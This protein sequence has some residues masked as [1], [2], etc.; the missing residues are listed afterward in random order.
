MTVS[1]LEAECRALVRYLSGRDPP[2]YVVACY[3]RSAGPGEPGL[4]P[5]DRGLMRA[6][7][8]ARWLARPAD[9]YARAARPAGLLRRRLTLA[10]AIL[11][12]A[13]ESHRELNDARVGAPF[14]IWVWLSAQAARSATSL[15]VG[16]LLFGPLHLFTALRTRRDPEAP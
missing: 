9:A 14:G 1:P 8:A 7:C 4:D 3:T 2:P 12:N 10:V 15:A 6:A 5:L 11:E 16:I 13:P